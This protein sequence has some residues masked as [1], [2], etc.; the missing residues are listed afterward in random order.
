MRCGAALSIPP[1]L[2]VMVVRCTYCGTEQ[3]VPDLIERQR[4]WQQQQFQAQHQQQ[5]MAHMQ[6]AQQSG[7]SMQKMI[8]LF[9]AL[10]LVG[11]LLFTAAMMAKSFGF[12]LS[13]P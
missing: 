7:R 13:D 3:P 2:S 5:M 10:V 12:M 11:S 6:Q 9:V 4:A 1:E 8:F